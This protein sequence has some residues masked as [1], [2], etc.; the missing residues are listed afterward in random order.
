MRPELASESDVLVKYSRRGL[1]L[2][3]TLL[4]VLGAY[5]IVINL[6]PDGEA[7]ALAHRLFKMLPIALVIA[8]AAMRSS[9]TGVRGAAMKALLNDELRRQSLSLSYRNGL[10]AVL[11]AQPLLFLLLASMPLQHPMA[12]MAC[13]TSL[14]GVAAVLGSM[15][16][17]DR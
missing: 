7:A 4:L 8:L 3:L 9:L 6:A 5:A 13:A 10:L 14:I 2:A 11:L 17:Y 12:L 16:V 15:L 1:W